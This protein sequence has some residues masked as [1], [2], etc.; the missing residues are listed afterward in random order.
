MQILFVLVDI[1]FIFGKER[2]CVHDYIAGTKVIDVSDEVYEV[3]EDDEVAA[4]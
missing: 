2:R 4:G 3:D 1:L